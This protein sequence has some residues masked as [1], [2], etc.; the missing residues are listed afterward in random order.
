MKNESHY[1]HPVNLFISKSYDDAET[2]QEFIKDL[3]G[4]QLSVSKG[5]NG[6]Y[7]YVSIEGADE[8]IDAFLEVY[9]DEY[10]DIVKDFGVEGW[11]TPED[12]YYASV[13]GKK[14]L[15]GESQKNERGNDDYLQ[16]VWDSLEGS[17]D[18]DKF[19]M[20]KGY[21]SEY[22]C[23]CITITSKDNEEV[24]AKIYIEDYEGRHPVAFN[25]VYRYPGDKGVGVM[26]SYEFQSTDMD[27]IGEEVFDYFDEIK[28]K[29]GESMKNETNSPEEEAVKKVLMDASD[30]AEFRREAGTDFSAE[31]FEKSID[32]NIEKLRDVFLEV[33]YFDDGSFKCDVNDHEETRDICSYVASKVAYILGLSDSVETAIDGYLLWYVVQENI[34]S[35]ESKKSKSRFGK[36][37]EGNA[38]DYDGKYYVDIEDED[39]DTLYSSDMEFDS[40]R[41][42]SLWA[43]D[44]LEKCKDDDDVFQASV[45]QLFINDD[46]DLDHELVEVIHKSD[47]CESKKS[48]S[49]GSTT[50]DDALKQMQTGFKQY[51]G[52]TTGEI[53]ADIRYD[54]ATALDMPADEVDDVMQSFGLDNIYILRAEGVSPKAIAQ[55]IL[56][57]NNDTKKSESD[58]T[59]WALE[60]LV[61][62]AKEKG[63]KVSWEEANEICIT[64]GTFPHQDHIFVTDDAPGKDDTSLELYVPAAH[65][66][67]SG[68]TLQDVL[69][70]LDDPIGK[71]DAV[72]FKNGNK[73]GKVEAKK[74]EGLPP[75]K[76]GSNRQYRSR[77]DLINKMKTLDAVEITTPAQF[78]DIHSKQWLHTAGYAMDMNGN[79]VGQT[80]FGDKDG[81]WYY[82]TTKTFQGD[83]LPECKESK[84]SESSQAITPENI[85]ALL[86][87]KGLVFRKEGTPT[88]PTYTVYDSIETKELAEQTHHKVGN[89][90]YIAMNP[91]GGA[92]IS[93]LCLG[94]DYY[95]NN[96]VKSDI[97]TMRTLRK[98]V[99]LIMSWFKYPNNDERVSE[100]LTLKQKE[101]KDMARFG[102][103]EDITTISDAE[104][105]ELKKKGI[106][107][108]GISRGVYGMNGALLRDKDGNKYVITARSS[109]LFYFV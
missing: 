109:N 60:Y 64:V 52:K 29:V 37:V 85:E 105:K 91:G 17:W 47:V 72:Q 62:T 9:K 86:D 22:D 100:S 33:L 45:Y 81:K 12:V 57:A 54:V 80:Y 71:R 16:E 36:M 79:L 13:E 77:A 102:Q 94:G 6:D 24:R 87:E 55:K 20:G 92:F 96:F 46:G 25:V 84:K 73:L 90:F 30:D 59:S 31:D 28:K 101:L 75:K 89:M 26:G 7:L 106:E 103:A 32:A 51:N 50:G 39:E 69:D 41:K 53:A 11:V 93:V 18:K 35:D 21:D 1:E 38:A 66:N 63:L 67:T 40:S 74:S 3:A 4:E 107:T 97:A 108:V 44:E 10:G 19:N 68:L 56:K 95:S 2:A 70:Y 76:L 98:Y 43:F 99:D 88:R 61:E 65:I 83:Y 48:E 49:E 14:E 27:G 42:A 58:K 8:D 78:N 104:A 34:V 82:A 15:L 5:R 23:E